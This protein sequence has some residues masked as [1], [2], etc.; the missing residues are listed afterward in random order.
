[1]RIRIIFSVITLIFIGS[2]VYFIDLKSETIGRFQSAALNLAYADLWNLYR[3]GPGS[4]DEGAMYDAVF[5][6]P[7]VSRSTSSIF[8]SCFEGEIY[9]RPRE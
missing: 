6:P 1:M 3:S 9:S 7:P 2:F 8:L 5:C 4:I